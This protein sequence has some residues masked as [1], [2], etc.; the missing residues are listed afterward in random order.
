MQQLAGQRPEDVTIDVCAS[1]SFVS[2]DST[3]SAIQ[4]SW[5]SFSTTP[6]LLRYRYKAKTSNSWSSWVNLT[7]T[8][9]SFN[10]TITTGTEREYQVQADTSSLTNNYLHYGNIL[11]GHA[12]P[13]NEELG[14]ILILVDSAYIGVL[15]S[16]LEAFKWSLWLDGYLPEIDYIDNSTNPPYVKSVISTSYN[17]TG[18]SSLY[19]VLLLGH[20]PV[21][22]SGDFTGSGLG[23]F[24]PDGHTTTSAPPSHEGAWSTDFYYG[25]LNGSWTDNTVTNTA[26]AR[27]ENN[28]TTGDGKFDQTLRPSNVEIPVGRVDF[29][30]LSG[31]T[32]SDTTLMLRYLAKDVAY[33]SGQT[34]YVGRVLQDDHLQLLTGEPFGGAS[35]QL[36]NPIWGDSVAKL[37]WNTTLQTENYQWS[38][39]FGFGA[40]NNCVNV[41]SSA[42]FATNTYRTTFTTLFGSYF[43]DFDSENNLMRSALASRGEILTCAW[44]GRPKWYFHQM[45]TGNP[46]GLSVM[47]SQNNRNGS[48]FIYPDGL[49]GAGLIHTTFQ[50]DISLK[51]YPYEQV[52][53]LSIRQDSCNQSFVLSWGAHQDSNITGYLI[54]R[55]DTL[56]SPFDTSF[57]V[58]DT[59]FTDHSPASGMNYYVV[60]AI[61]SITNCSGMHYEMSYGILDSIEYRLPVAY[62]GNDTSACFNS[63][64]NIG[65]NYTYGDDDVFNWTPTSN[66]LESS[67]PITTIQLRGSG[68]SDLV[69]SVTDTLSG[70]VAL[71]TA[72]VSTLALPSDSINRLYTSNSCGD[73]ISLRSNSTAGHAY[74]WSF[75]SWTPATESGAGPHEV[76]W[77]ATGNYN[78]LLVVQDSLT[79][80]V[81][82]DSITHPVACVLPQELLTFNYD[83]SDNCKSL[84]IDFTTTNEYDVLGYKIVL[85]KS[86]RV[87]YNTVLSAASFSPSQINRYSH[88]VALQK[89]SEADE[90]LLIAQDAN[91]ISSIIGRAS[92]S[93]NPCSQPIQI[94]PNP[95]K[96]K[97]GQLM[98]KG[99][100]ANEHVIIY[101]S[102]GIKVYETIN[103]RNSQMEIPIQ[104]EP[105]TYLVSVNGVVFKWILH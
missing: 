102:L 60:H 24:P 20:I 103:G 17:L 70:C 93:V 18:V 87:L 92:I 57:Q 64:V 2:T 29:N 26:G 7:S 16:A 52:N 71:D 96:A 55:T 81:R 65:S 80:C 78:L 98:V 8:D 45:A 95:A 10:D 74:N 82:N 100:E 69:L 33:R 101:N 97:A 94:I 15:D 90:V 83:Y 31:F 11:A 21:P 19:G 75:T 42:N 48:Q 40:Y 77:N 86:G 47:N 34:S 4:V 14:R 89:I 13:V 37:D 63:L 41:V 44:G 58:T 88:S 28:N 35:F 61:K 36:S 25:D 54:Q 79:G 68:S 3:R 43:G 99:L 32:E 59:S 49:Y 91:G 105:G 51:L 53:N 46:I 84:I 73:T 56:F 76:Y 85:R 27:M 39:G 9:T 67:A 38:Q 50:G 5:S 1:T 62:A 22:Y 23:Y 30:D 12:V 66:I 6:L 104:W 72:V